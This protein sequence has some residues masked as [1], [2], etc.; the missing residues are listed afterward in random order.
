[1]ACERTRKRFRNASITYDLMDKFAERLSERENFAEIV[2]SEIG[3]RAVRR[4]AFAADLDNAD[5]FFAGKNR[6]ADYFL[7]Q[8][9]AGAF[10][11]H[12]FEHRGVPHFGEIVNDFG[13]AF[14][15]CFGGDRGSAGKRNEAD[16]L[17]RFGH[18]KV[19]MPPAF[20]DTEQRD[21]RRLHA[22]VVRNAFGEARQGDF[23]GR[24][25]VGFERRGE[26][27]QFRCE[28]GA[29]SRHNFVC[30]TGQYVSQA[31]R[32]LAAT[33]FASSIYLSGSRRFAQ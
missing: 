23:R 12:A 19:Q 29:D 30:N 1:M 31:G 8:V 15:R 32:A 7:N 11:F 33:F 13:A 14:A 5:D 18:E 16:L 3:S 24:S 22:D 17:E 10:D 9:A 4:G 25:G 2:R 20:R 27:I 28:A 6:R 26:S 21:F